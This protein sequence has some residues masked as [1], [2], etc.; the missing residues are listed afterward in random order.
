M[1]NTNKQNEPQVITLTADKIG[2]YY[3]NTSAATIILK[4][5]FENAQNKLA[6]VKINLG[7]KINEPNIQNSLHEMENAISGSLIR[8]KE[9][10]NNIFQIQIKSD[11][12]STA[13]L[14]VT[15]V[16]LIFGVLGLVVT[17][18]QLL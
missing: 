18:I 3:F 12:T 2:E 9:Q 17:L 7:E 14:I 11:K 4:N 8:L 13:S 10:N 16:S 1:E 5:D 15:I 6:E